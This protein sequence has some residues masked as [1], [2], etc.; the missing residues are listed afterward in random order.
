MAWWLAYTYRHTHIMSCTLFWMNALCSSW[1]W[2]VRNSDS[3]E[4]D[5]SVCLYFYH[6]HSITS[7]SAMCLWWCLVGR[8]YIT[9]GHTYIQVVV[10][11]SLSGPWAFQ[12]KLTSWVCLMSGTCFGCLLFIAC[13]SVGCHSATDIFSV[14][15]L[16]K[17]AKAV[18][19]L[20]IGRAHQS[21]A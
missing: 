12:F 4:S 15:Q 6:V 10:L 1:L 2:T 3:T 17:R 14:I 8:L 13:Q 21:H 5:W 11:R 20:T 18:I 19:S 9:V 7:Q 16:V